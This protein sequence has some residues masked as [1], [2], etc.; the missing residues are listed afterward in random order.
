MKTIKGKIPEQTIASYKIAMSL[1]CF[2]EESFGSEIL[3]GAIQENAT[4]FKVSVKEKWDTKKPKKI[5]WFNNGE[6]P[7]IELLKG[8][9]LLFNKTPHKYDANSISAKGLGFKMETFRTGLFI[10]RMIPGDNGYIIK[11]EFKYLDTNEKEIPIEEYSMDRIL[12]DCV[13]IEWKIYE[14]DMLNETYFIN[15]KGLIMNNFVYEDCPIDVDLL[16]IQDNLLKAHKEVKIK[17]FFNDMSKEYKNKVVKHRAFNKSGE[18]IKSYTEFE[19][20][21]TPLSINYDDEKLQFDV[22]YIH[23]IMKEHDALKF[24]DFEK[25]INGHIEYAIKGKR[26]G[27]PLYSV[28]G[29]QEIILGCKDAHSG[30]YTGFD[31]NKRQGLEIFLRPRQNMSKFFNAVK[32]EGYSNEKLE[33]RIELG[34]VE[35]IK[36]NGEFISPYYEKSKKAEDSLGDQF[37]DLIRD[38]KEGKSLRLTYS[39]FGVDISKMTELSNWEMRKTPEFFEA[40]I[41]YLGNVKIWWELQKLTS[42][43]EHLNGLIT[44]IM[45]HHTEYDYF[46]WTADKHTLYNELRSL[47]KNIDYKSNNRLKKIYMIT[48]DQLLEGFELNEIIQEFD[49]EE[50]IKEK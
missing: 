19:K 46:F 35:L 21:K 26:K 17:M 4:E 39:Q 3:H 5:E 50:I 38:K 8:R 13:D 42:D 18:L 25:K 10:D 6:T 34:L 20:Y 32:T 2:T 31:Y 23:R 43:K 44:R 11:Q 14:T 22:Y 29:P 41:V 9:M 48:N 7:S 30:W 40:D 47:L 16:S 33:N 1:S 12:N 27:A 28:V 15:S 24:K 36:S 45:R 49:I 37:V